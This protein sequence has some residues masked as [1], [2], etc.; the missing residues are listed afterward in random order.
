MVLLMKARIKY[1]QVATSRLMVAADYRKFLDSKNAINFKPVGARSN[2]I[3][4]LQ[5]VE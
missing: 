4:H 1:Y 3:L 2:Y 5:N